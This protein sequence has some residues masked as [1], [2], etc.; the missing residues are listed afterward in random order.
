MFAI[1]FSFS[2]VIASIFNDDPSVID[3]AV[4]F[5]I[6]LPISYGFLGISWLVNSVFN[7][8]N[9]PLRASLVIV[10]HL[11]AFVLPLAYL[12]SKLY[13]L[14][15]IF[16]GMAVGNALVGIFSYLMVHKFLFQVEAEIQTS[17]PEVAESVSG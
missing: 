11:F 15:G 5:L 3:S 9:R 4:I 8:L 12:G 10:L 17:A 1:L 13:G 16:I 14:K 7:A 6:I 2:G